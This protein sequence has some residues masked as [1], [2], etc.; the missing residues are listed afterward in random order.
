MMMMSHCTKRRRYIQHIHLY[1]PPQRYI[2]YIT[3][4]AKQKPC[5]SQS[6]TVSA[7]VITA[8]KTE[9]TQFPKGRVCRLVSTVQSKEY[10]QSTQ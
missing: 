2:R 7:T 3:L 10:E 4:L 8:D 1:I 6:T 9:A 5:N